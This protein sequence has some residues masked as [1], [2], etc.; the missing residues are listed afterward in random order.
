MIVEL[1]KSSNLTSDSMLT[2][3]ITDVFLHM[4]W[5]DA[6]I[7]TSVLESEKAT[8]DEELLKILHHI[9]ETQHAFLSAWLSGTFQRQTFDSFDGVSELAAWGED[10][11]VSVLPYTE[12]LTDKDLD[13]K[14]ILPWAHYFSRVLGRKPG[15]TTI[16]ETLHQLPSHSMHHRG[17]AARRL[18]ELEVAPPLMDYIVWVMGER[19]VIPW[20]NI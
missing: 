18:R 13:K 16:R 11:H 7:W 1:I 9:H 10:F 14:I 19:P 15:P 6:K 20:P 3:H 4:K 2:E 12:A 8:S 5:A 17:Q